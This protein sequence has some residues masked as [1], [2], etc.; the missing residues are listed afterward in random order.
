MMSTVFKRYLR[1]LSPPEQKREISKSKYNQ[2]TIERNTV[3]Q[4]AFMN[5]LDLLVCEFQ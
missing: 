2:K 1:G 4:L 5:P 3:L